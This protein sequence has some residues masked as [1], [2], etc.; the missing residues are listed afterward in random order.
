MNKRLYFLDNLRGIVIFMVVVLHVFL[1]Y[2]K[3]APSWWYVIDPRQSMFFTYGVI[4][5][6]VPIMPIMFFIAGYFSLSSLQK[7]GVYEFWAAKFRRIIIPW[8][9]GVFFLAPPSMYMILL[10][11]GKAPAS[12]IEFWFGQFWKTMFSQSV[13]WFLGLLTL[14]YLI[15]TVSYKFIGSLQNIKREAKKPSVML[16]V[17]FIAVTSGIFLGMNQFFAVDKWVTDYYIIIFQP[18][19]V[20]LYFL[21]FGLG[22]LAWK[23]RWFET[24]GFMPKIIP[25]SVLFFVSAIF[26]LNFKLMMAGRGGELAI[27]TGNAFGFNLFAY[28][29]MMAGLALFQRLLNSDGS[30]WKSFSASSYG[31]YIFHSIAVYYG[32]YYL[33]R[34]DASP[35][36]KVPIL[37]S[38]SII[39][40]WALTV[41]LKKSRIISRII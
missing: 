27:Q 17:L 12:Y 40:C 6:D 28:S 23:R 37:L 13:F 3:Y 21:Y 4:L 7:H 10:S 32:A 33:L 18:V 35:F 2:M 39:I 31:I 14:C 9:L 29:A 34:M 8:V 11:R 26:Y 5:I 20:F 15:L 1:C 19:R 22:V 30:L 38:A 25:W 36:V 24:S 16:S 41:L